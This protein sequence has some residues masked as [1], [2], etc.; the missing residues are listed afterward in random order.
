MNRLKFFGIAISLALAAAR[1]VAADDVC[2]QAP[3]TAT[4]QLEFTRSLIHDA[5]YFRAV[6][7]A[8]RY[9]SFFEPCGR[10]DEARLY[11]GVA[12]QRAEQW[13]KAAEVFR[14]LADSATGPTAAIAHL[15][16]A[17][18]L[19]RQGR[20]ELAANEYGS[21]AAK[22]T[23][24]AYAGYARYREG[25]SYF[26]GRRRDDAGRAFRLVADDAPEKGRAERMERSLA[27]EDDLPYRS[28][29]LAGVMSAVLP[30]AGQVYTGRWVDGVISLIV[31]AG[32]GFGAYEAYRNDL[33]VVA[34]MVA[35]FEVGW[36]TGNIFS[37][38][39]YAYRFNER[40][41]EGYQ[42]E[43]MQRELVERDWASEAAGET[44]YLRFGLDF[45]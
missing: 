30:G 32:F 8:R 29:V 2:N 1:P 31:N 44:R 40:A 15:A 13:D 34:T 11:V 10:L 9:L 21:F 7:E 33:P 39:N 3:F 4:K 6:G 28:P 17:D 45:E 26:L 38:V 18:T 12:Y 37:S 5:E 42:R 16:L 23:D 27:L 41:Y 43:W 24:P 35:L 14:S 36:Y 25:F 19:F 20:Y 22:V